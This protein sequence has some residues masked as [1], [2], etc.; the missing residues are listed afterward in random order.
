MIQT[1]A[2]Q[3]KRQRQH[4]SQLRDSAILE[5][6]TQPADNSLVI[7]IPSHSKCYCL[8]NLGDGPSDSCF[9]NFLRLVNF[10]Y[11]LGLNKLLSRLKCFNWRGEWGIATS[12]T[13]QSLIRRSKASTIT[14]QTFKELIS[15]LKTGSLLYQ[16]IVQM[17]VK[18]QIHSP[19]YLKKLFCFLFVRMYAYYSNWCFSLGISSTT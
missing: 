12:L 6:F 3:M 15:A 1:E 11:F 8:C 19:K 14:G 7:R 9:R 4:G 10:D 2:P 17:K 5:F 18:L 13:T 16:F